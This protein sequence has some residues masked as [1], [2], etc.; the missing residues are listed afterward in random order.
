MIKGVARALS[1]LHSELASYDLPHG[2]LKSCNVLIG[3]DHEALVSDYALHPL[4]N[5]TP[6]AQSMFAYR[7][8]EA[9][10]GH[11]SDVYCL[12]IV[13]LEVV[14][15]KYPSQYVVNY[16]NQKGESGTDVVQWVRSALD[17]KRE[18]EL[19][20]SEA[21]TTGEEECVRQM[22]KLLRIG[23]AC[24]E[25]EVDTRIDLKEAITRIE[26]V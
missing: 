19:I 13:I 18:G 14:T 3:K 2:N 4:I 20:D 24:T 23:A 9:I 8:P 16:N 22:E 11:K 10:V 7:S 12:G 15:G 21:V 1:Y 6:T 25:T 26:D 17:E 5:N